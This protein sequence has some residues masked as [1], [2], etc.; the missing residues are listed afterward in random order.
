MQ[1]PSTP[2]PVRLAHALVEGGR[3]R[4]LPLLSS[5]LAREI[6]AAG[7]SPAA[8]ERIYA[9]RGTGGPLARF[10]DRMVLDTPTQHA[11]RERREAAA[12]EI[13]A[14]A[15]LACRAG[16]P[17]FRVLAAPCGLAADVRAAADTL[18]DHPEVRTATRV[19]GVDADPDGRLLP[20]AT[21]LAAAAGLRFEPIREDIRRLR[22][23]DAVAQKVGGFHLV[24]L[25][26]LTDACPPSEVGRLVGYYAQRLLPGGT[27]LIDR[28]QP[29]D[30]TKLT[31][32]LGALPA[33]CPAADLRR[34]LA[35]AGLEVEREHPT[36]EGGCV[37]MVARKAA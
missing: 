35:R 14:A 29:T 32:G 27:L 21:R 28:W 7:Y 8:L 36:G 16:A 25:V 2:P 30:R 26:G 5:P 3:S 22:E 24:S 19:W 33:A 6:L 23:V 13:R 34:A 18:A 1:S 12:G 37:L 11:L 9:N 10:A 31:Q 17:E 15:V 20:E 4:A